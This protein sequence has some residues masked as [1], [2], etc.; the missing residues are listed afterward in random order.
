VINFCETLG[1]TT[2]AEG[3]ETEQQMQQRAQQTAVRRRAT[4]SAPPGR[5]PRSQTAHR[6][7][8]GLRLASLIR[9]TGCI[10]APHRQADRRRSYCLDDDRE[11]CCGGWALRVCYPT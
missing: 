9:P 11:R 2:L 1:M 8:G 5:H 4:F 6:R 7:R 10:E 3:V